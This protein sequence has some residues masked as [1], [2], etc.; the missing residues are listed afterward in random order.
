MADIWSNH[1]CQS[2]L[3]VTAHWIT[4]DAMTGSLILKVALLAFHCL[5]GTHDGKSMAE[6]VIGLLDCTNITAN[7]STCLNYYI[8]VT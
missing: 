6:A 8:I 5:Y 2:Y 7:V 3:C 1:N 4:K